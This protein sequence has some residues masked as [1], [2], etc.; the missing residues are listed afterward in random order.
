MLGEQPSD[1]SVNDISSAHVSVT[2]RLTDE[3]IFGAHLETM[4]L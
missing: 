1:V 2:S 3:A 4:G